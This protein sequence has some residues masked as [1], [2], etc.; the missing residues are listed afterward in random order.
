MNGPV[1]IVFAGG[2]TGGHVY[3]ALAVAD[4][5][6]RRIG[7]FEALFI[8]T[9]VGLEAKVVSEA[10]YTMK[11]IHARGF[12]G[13]GVARKFLTLVGIAVG[14]VQA[15]WIVA[16]NRPDLVFGAGGYA[17]AAVVI[18]ASFLGKTIVLQEQNSIPGMTNRML[19]S[20]A[21][22]I[23]LGFE[24]AAEMF[25]DHPGLVVTGNPLRRSVL[26]DVEG[27]PKAAFGLDAQGPVL[28]VF[29][30]SQGSHSLNRAAVDFFL[31]SGDVQGIVQTGLRDYG[32]VRDRLR[33]VG[34][35][36]FVSPYISNI[37]VAYRAAD[38]ALA[39]AG[40]LS[41]S[42]LSAV[43]LPSILVPYPYAAD[44]HQVSNARILVETGGA[45]MITDGELSGEALEATVAALMNDP[46]RLRRMKEALSTI[47]R[48][49]AAGRIAEDICALLG[50][51]ADRATGNHSE[52]RSSGR[53]RC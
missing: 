48:R 21:A 38:V 52:T 11:F 34:G 33:D 41:I 44:D 20:R 19:A 39:R 13:R 51:P 6:R 25:G 7:D 24:R 2:G 14:V 9:K 32:W 15:I 53:G 23:Y 10:S 22:R 3:P 29:G 36:V 5:L 45:V 47:A 27:D 16:A 46:E 49:D 31:R 8:G 37:H 43:G 30:G 35:R 1:K 28:L 12:R 18:A 26:D 17:S 50:A 4:A 42:E 40:A